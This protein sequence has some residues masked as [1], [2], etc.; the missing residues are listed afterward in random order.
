M[1]VRFVIFKVACIFPAVFQVRAGKITGYPGEFFFDSVNEC[2]ERNMLVRHSS[3][4]PGRRI[5]QG[6]PEGGRKSIALTVNETSF[7]IANAGKGEP[8]GALILALSPSIF[9]GSASWQIPAGLGDSVGLAKPGRGNQGSPA[10]L[11][12]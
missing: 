8:S 4:T 10:G 3:Q 12:R 6:W 1:K 7:F 2:S 11:Q 9:S 5:M